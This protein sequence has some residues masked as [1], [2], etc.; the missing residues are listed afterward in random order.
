MTHAEH[1]AIKAGLHFQGED[2]S[3]DSGD[4]DRPYIRKIGIL[5]ELIRYNCMC[6]YY[7]GRN[8][9]YYEVSI[10]MTGRTEF[11]KLTKHKKVHES[12]QFW[13]LAESVEGLQYLWWFKLDRN[14]W[15][16]GRS[17]RL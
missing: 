12:I 17:T 15:R 14:D 2:E 10:L 13:A 8:L 16:L 6:A 11:R 4:P 5:M 3:R 7:Q 9:A 1:Q